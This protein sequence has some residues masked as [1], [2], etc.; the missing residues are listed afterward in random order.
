MSPSLPVIV[1]P[2]LLIVVAA[3]GLGVIALRTTHALQGGQCDWLPADPGGLRFRSD[4]GLFELDRGRTSL[5]VTGDRQVATVPLDRPVHVEVRRVVA[6]APQ[7]LEFVLGAGTFDLFEQSGPGLDWHVVV[8]VLD[9]G[10]EVPVYAVGQL[11]LGKAGVM[12]RALRRVGLVHDAAAEAQSV[13]AELV[14]H[15]PTLVEATTDA[16]VRTALA[17]KTRQ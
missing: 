1:L 17:T 12:G 15:L 11:A 10:R 13:R 14:R 7:W 3:A 6:L 9:D 2:S 5:R 8:I 16:V 4:F